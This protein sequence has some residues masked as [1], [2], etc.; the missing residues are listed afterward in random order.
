MNKEDKFMS[1]DNDLFY[2]NSLIMFDE[3]NKSSSFGIMTGILGSAK[4]NNEDINIFINSYGGFTDDLVAMID[5]MNLVKNDISTIG[6]GCC[7]SCGAI[8]LACGTPGKR[9]ITENARV[10]I[11]QVSA[12]ACGKV[13]EMKI[14]VDEAKRVNEQIAT[15][16][17]KATKKPKK[18]ILEDIKDD[19]WFS[20]EEAL[21]YGLVDKI[22]KQEDIK[23]M[24]LEEKKFDRNKD[25]NF[26]FNYELKSFDSDDD[27]YILE[28]YASTPDVDLCN[29]IM[30]Q[31]A[32]M[33]SLKKHGKPSFLH[34]HNQDEK[35]LGVIEKVELQD[36]KTYIK[37]R[38]PKGIVAN[39]EVATLIKKGAYKGLSVG[40]SVLDYYYK[41]NIRII[42]DII[43]LE[44]SLV[45]VPANQD[46]KLLGFK[47][48]KV[49]NIESALLKVKNAKSLKDIEL[50]L[51]DKG[52]SRPE[53]LTCVSKIKE[54]SLNKDPSEMS[55]SSEDPSEA[56]DLSEEPSVSNLQKN[57]TEKLINLQNTINNSLGK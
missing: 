12:G 30:Q 46:A 32:L 34:Q 9:Y 47:N 39:D 33:K 29:D 24:P 36:N 5:T 45:S 26:V 8:L 6:L 7:A 14:T 49:D 1:I 21:E 16:L 35:P 15:L 38:M 3:F 25:E 51:K 55:D 10:M 11:H 43:W 37:A 22:I 17:A 27:D 23:K 28:G 4:D 18:Q 31:D 57:L 52:L 13:S 54:L 44:V 40:Y 19:K 2:Y 56:S 50:V 53:I 20:A 42:T 48:K 41:N